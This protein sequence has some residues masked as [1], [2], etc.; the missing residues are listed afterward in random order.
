LKEYS[1]SIF[2][3]KKIVLS[4]TLYIIIFAVLGWNPSCSSHEWC[5]HCFRENI[6]V[7]TGECL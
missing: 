5:I 3:L 4:L 1:A 7:D 2:R 6:Q